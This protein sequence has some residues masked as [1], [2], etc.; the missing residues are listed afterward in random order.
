MNKAR[1]LFLLFAGVLLLAGCQKGFLERK[2]GVE[3]RFTVASSPQT[4][5][6]YD[7]GSY[8]GY[9]RI[10]WIDGDQVLIWGDNAH[11]NGSDAIV[12]NASYDI[13]G[14]SVQNSNSKSTANLVLKET[15]GLVFDEDADSYN[16]AA[17]YPATGFSAI[18]MTDDGVVKSVKPSIP[19]AQTLTDGFPDMSKA[20]LLGTPVN[21]EFAEPVRL[22]FTPIYTMF[23]FTICAEKDMKVTGVDLISSKVVN[24]E[25]E[26]GPSTMN[27]PYDL[28]FNFTQGWSISV[29]NEVT[30]ES[31]QI[32]ATF[33][34]PI[35]LT[36]EDGASTTN[37]ATFAVL[38]VPN[39]IT[40]LSVVFHVITDDG[41][42]TRT[43]RV[44]Y[45]KDDEGGK[46]SKG[47]PV[48]FEKCKKHNI[49]GITLPANMAPNVALDLKVIPWED[50]TGTITYGPGQPVVSAIALEYASGAAI[51]EG[52][53]RRLNNNFANATDPIKA[54]FYVFSP[55]DATWKIKIA[56]ATDKF[57][58]TSANATSTSAKE[59]SGAVNG[60]TTNP[61]RVDFTIAMN[62]ATATD[63]IQLT[64][65]LMLGD[66]EISIDSEIIRGK[67]LTITG[68]VGQ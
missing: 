37:T 59:L 50:E 25:V 11:V 6:A 39:D 35:Q 27:G 41:E 43:L 18:S 65:S 23:Q 19:A 51:N 57:T 45:A 21:V 14:S 12:R 16:F 64:F 34:T 31:S 54:Y 1:Y 48:N 8:G 55:T 17:I 40:G 46:Y 32:S 60:N 2:G 62:G 56:G 22:E 7:G 58:V 33:A 24:N 42:E 68:K 30:E 13:D 47:D 20:V 36:K 52:E 63:K 26:F 9:D 44:S 38:A 29:P 67:E 10:A 28:N 4:K 5:T 49:T 15:G 66:R 3:V 61:G 53:E